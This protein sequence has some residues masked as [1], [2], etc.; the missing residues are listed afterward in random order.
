M[1]LLHGY[2]RS[3]TSY[4]LR[5]AMNF[6]GLDYDQLPV[7]LK[8]GD[9]RGA[10]YKALN[11]QGLVP[12]LEIDGVRLIQSPAILE[13]LEETHPEPPLLPG[14]PAERARIR[15]YAAVIGCDIHPIQNLRIL[16]YLRTTYEQD[17]DGVTAWCQRW[18]GDGFAALEKM[19]EADNRS[20]PYL[21]GGLPTMADVYLVPQM[22]NARRFGLAL[23]AFP[24]LVAADEAAQAHP[25]F[26]AAR[27]ENQPDT[28][29]DER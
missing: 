22:Y 18:I 12:L 27:P 24:R 21:W 28:P 13:Y 6:K 29:E 7:N 26:E 10:A 20:G 8:D 1:T 19:A 23:D 2:W 9:Q 17:S 11:P 14:T 4:R 5:I 3:G 16:Q 25:A 15:A